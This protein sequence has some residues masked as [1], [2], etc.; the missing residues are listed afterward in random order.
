[1]AI[2]HLLGAEIPH[3]NAT[4]L[5]FF[6]QVLSTQV[7]RATA[8]QFMVVSKET[9]LAKR[10]PQLSIECF[11]SKRD[12]ARAVSRRARD[13]TNQ[14]FCHGQFNPYLW[15]ALLTG[16]L[17]RHQCHWHIWGAD[18]YQESRALKFKLFYLMRRWAQGRVASVWA[19]LGDLNYYQQR[20]PQV[21]TSPL[22]FPTKMPEIFPASS[23]T[24]ADQPL[25]IL[26]GNSGD[27]SN[28]H[29]QGLAHIAEQFGQQV[30]IV[31]PMGYPDNNDAYIQQVA[32][33]AARLFPSSQVT[34]LTHKLGF[35]E[36]VDWL[37]SCQLGYFI[38]ARQ[39]GIGTLS[40]LIAQ[41]IPFVI[42]RNNPFWRDLASQQLPLLFAEDLLSPEIIADA[43]RQLQRF[44]KQQ[45]AFF[46][47][48][49][50]QGWREMLHRVEGVG[51]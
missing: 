28:R 9:E 50:I 7:K 36:Y 30:E 44:D 38:F 51:E 29:C 41:N 48:G 31:I 8:R 18:L 15:V 40:L 13:R 23:G 39:Q 49:Y 47:P 2:I 5:T 19:T 10:Y 20:Y 4:L 27:A 17:Q 34:V 24:A 22:Y 25:R 1:M 12:L 37:K 33:Q 16:Q 46:S 6:D 43:H 11:P 21:T 42:S 14:F 32:A 26:L 3:H 45:I 35:E